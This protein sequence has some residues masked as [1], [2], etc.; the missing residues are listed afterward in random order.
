ML[1]D[2]DH[3]RLREAASLV[4]DVADRHPSGDLRAIAALCAAL[5]EI[6]LAERYADCP[7]AWSTR[8]PPT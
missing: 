4:K 1:T 6:R 3:A 7:S 8:R 2:Q 5:Q